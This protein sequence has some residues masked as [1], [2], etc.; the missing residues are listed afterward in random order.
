[1][2]SQGCFLADS[3][4]S[5]MALPPAPSPEAESRIPGE[6]HL[7]VSKLGLALPLTGSPK[8]QV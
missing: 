5:Q 8:S 7:L 3:G 6:Q 2:V 4:D 1:M